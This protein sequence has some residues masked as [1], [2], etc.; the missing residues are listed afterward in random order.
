MPFLR[1]CKGTNKKQYVKERFM[2]IYYLKNLI[3]SKLHELEFRYLCSIIVIG[4]F[5]FGG[6]CNAL[7]TQFLEL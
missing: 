1:G 4:R 3:L 6:R 5:A 7:D 2:M